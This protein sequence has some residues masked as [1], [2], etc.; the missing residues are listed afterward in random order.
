[1][2][3][4]QTRAMYRGPVVGEDG[5][6]LTEEAIADA[7]SQDKGFWV[8]VDS[9]VQAERITAQPGLWSWKLA[10]KFLNQDGTAAV[11][12]AGSQLISRV[13]AESYTFHRAL[14][15]QKEGDRALETVAAALQSS[16]AVMLKCLDAQTRLLDTLPALIKDATSAAAS[17]AC[18][19]AQTAAQES[20]KMLSAG[21]SPLQQALDIIA[22][23]AKHETARADDATIAHAKLLLKGSD[24]DWTDTAVKLFGAAPAVLKL[25]DKLMN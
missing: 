4:G 13:T 20:A 25:A 23:H 22:T 18:A 3:P 7:V 17:A 8:Y 14:K 15:P 10:V 19:V 1:M 6:F 11:L 21:S 9:Q 2:G 24:E 5:V 16:Q 12:D